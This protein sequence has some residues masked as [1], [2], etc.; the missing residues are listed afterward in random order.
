MNL[1]FPTPDAA[2]CYDRA[3]FDMLM[4]EMGVNEMKV[5]PARADIGGPG[6][7]CAAHEEVGERGDGCKDCPEYEA[8]NKCNGICKH[9]RFC[10]VPDETPVTLKKKV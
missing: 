10:R 5:W 9:W 8:R 7:F 2:Y 3:Y 1:Y 6:F 4:E